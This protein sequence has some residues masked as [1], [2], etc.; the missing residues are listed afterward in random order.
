LKINISGCRYRAKGKDREGKERKGKERKG[1]GRKGKGGGE[2]EKGSKGK[3]GWGVQV[4]LV[5]R[6]SSDVLVGVG[7]E[8]IQG[9]ETIRV[10][11]VG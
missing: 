10:F 8:Q 6:S 5:K 7:L 3:W 11:F 1:K 4:E 9:Q 2:E